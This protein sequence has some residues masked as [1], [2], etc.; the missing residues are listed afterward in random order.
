[1][2]EQKL[3][4]LWN[5]TD[6]ASSERSFQELF[7]ALSTGSADQAEVLTQIARAQGLQGHFDAAHATLDQALALIGEAPTRLRLRYLIE[8]GR[9]YNSSGQS[10]LALPLFRECWTLARE[11][12]EDFY[13]VDAA[14]MLGIA[15]PA[16]QQLGWNMR[17]LELARS[18]KQERAQRWQAS[19]NNNIGWFYHAQRDFVQALAHFERALE[20]RLAQGDAGNIRIARWCIGRA[21]RSLGRY[22]EALDIQQALHAER[23][24]AGESDGYVEEELAECLLITRG[25]EA[26]QPIF[27][28][29]YALLSQDTW[30]ATAEPER[31]ERLR[32]LGGH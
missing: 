1:L 4:Q 8:R 32:T 31:L 3:D 14:H 27:A 12:D 13:A 29:A 2:L 22:P 18:S 26:A 20:G 9:V 10:D 7:Q 19:L 17:A 24:L 11:L 23:E 5:Y 15:A 28:A 6:P 16:D 30:L 25:S 21:L